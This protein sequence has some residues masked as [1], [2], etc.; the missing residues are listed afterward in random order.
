MAAVF[1]VGLTGLYIMGGVPGLARENIDSGI[2]YVDDYRADL[3]LNGTLNEQFR[4]QMDGSY[5]DRISVP[6]P[7]RYPSR[8]LIIPTLKHPALSRCRELCPMPGTGKETCR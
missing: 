1:I 3:Y 5:L 6:G 2:N 4:Y 8:S 7:I